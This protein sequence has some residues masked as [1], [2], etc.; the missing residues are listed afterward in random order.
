M[1][2]RR[3]QRQRVG[4]GGCVCWGV[5]SWGWGMQA[6]ALLSLRVLYFQIWKELLAVGLGPAG[7]IGQSLLALQPML[8]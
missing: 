2:S 5:R 3:Q 7:G 1:H 4:E 8:A 6:C